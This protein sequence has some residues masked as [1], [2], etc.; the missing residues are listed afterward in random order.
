MVR[1]VW[2]AATKRGVNTAARTA[3]RR[4]VEPGRGPIE[5]LWLEVQDGA[6]DVQQAEERARDVLPD[7]AV[8][9]DALITLAEHGLKTTVGGD[10]SGG[11]ALGRLLL[12]ALGTVGDDEPLA[13]A[14][15]IAALEFVETARIALMTAPDPRLYRRAVD[16]G[17][18]ALD[19]AQA[20]DDVE[21][22]QIGTFRMGTLHLDP[23]TAD[24]T[25]DAYF[26]QH[27][28]W[29]ARRRDAPLYEFSSELEG[30]GFDSEG[31][32]IARGPD[33]AMPEPVEALRLAERYL[34]RATEVRV[35]RYKGQALKA[36]LQALAFL[37]LFGEPVDEAEV[38]RVGGEALALIPEDDFEPRLLVEITLR[39]FGVVGGDVDVERLEY[40]VKGYLAEA[41]PKQTVTAL[42]HAARLLGPTDSDRA[43][44]LL[45]QCREILA[46]HRDED[47]VSTLLMLEA[48]VLTSAAPPLGPAIAAALAARANPAAAMAAAEALDELERVAH[49]GGHADAI[50][51]L[52]AELRLDFGDAKRTEG[53][54]DAAAAAYSDALAA[55]VQLE[56][57]DRAGR[58]LGRLAHV[59]SAAS[60][61]TLQ[62]VL[63]TMWSTAAEIDARGGAETARLLQLVCARLGGAL[64]AAGTSYEAVLGLCQVA[65][66]IRFARVL[67]T[68]PP[69]IQL[70]DERGKR[71]LERIVAAE[72]EV[73]ADEAAAA[74]P[75][76]GAIDEETLLVGYADAIDR[77]LADTPLDRLRNRQ[78]AFDRHLARLLIEQSGRHRPAMLNELRTALDARTALLVFAVGAWLD[79]SFGEL[80]ILL[81]RDT[82]D[83]AF[84]MEP[85]PFADVQMGDEIT[86]LT[87]P[88]GPAYAELRRSIQA[89]PGPALV[90]TEPGSRLENLEAHVG[91]L[92]ESLA[93]LPSRGI[94]RLCV[95]PHGPRHYFPFHLV[96]KEGSPLASRMTVT[97]LPNLALLYSRGDAR[98]RRATPIASFGLGY[99]DRPRAGL[100]PIPK[101]R[102]EAAAVAA[103]FGEEAV[104][105]TDATKSRLITAL[106]QC[107]F[108]HLSAHGRHNVDA[109]SFQTI[110]LRG[111]S[112]E[113][114]LVAHELLSLDLRGLELVTLSACETALGRFDRNENLRG[115]PAAL[116]LAGAET[117]I[118]TLWPVSAAAARTFFPVLYTGVAA[119]DDVRDAF[120]AAQEET[121]R[122]Y[123]AYR[124]WG[125][126]YLAGGLSHQGGQR[127][128]RD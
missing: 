17:E 93:A 83:V 97:Y 10:V 8:T 87:S 46:E 100:P 58:S 109:P 112:G 64:L 65:K 68:L 7:P 26:E 36:R 82:E 81:T 34:R 78:R 38:R 122:Q 117:I 18:A 95:V 35:G 27:A 41:G 119:G 92:V 90:A 116:L 110:F 80:V 23:Y 31:R 54:T 19:W 96:G 16:A 101:A 76:A 50:R 111:E 127:N 33:A 105:E 104:P 29:L 94:D 113:G 48:Q 71:L 57:M 107:R 128:G 79:D 84:V 53:D 126:F 59:V 15:A 32:P 5:R 25:S 20:R 62:K 44:A 124:D 42:L 1:R 4:P 102:D 56:L 88:V 123:P 114:R 61:E 11:I 22:L 85:L 70:L 39:S 125:P 67:S 9:E 12:A 86:V 69:P 45:A 66:G 2:R 40:D 89:D 60:V 108:V 28:A 49:A 75:A 63:G 118:G 14:R 98:P 121:R 43:L 3:A 51:N 72:E 106:R 52:G 115:L 99:D 24:R 13:R 6:L 73:G 103:I 37:A 120:R 47:D 91:R 74:A 55:F 21:V 77:R 30:L